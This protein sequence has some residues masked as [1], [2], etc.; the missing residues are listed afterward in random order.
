MLLKLILPV[1]FS[2]FNMATMKFKM[3]YVAH[4]TFLLG[5]MDLGNIEL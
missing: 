4:I 1:S 5:S 2:F 3:I